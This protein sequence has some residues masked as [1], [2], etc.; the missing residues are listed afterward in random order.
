MPS[1]GGQ[2]AKF[3]SASPF[4]LFLSGAVVWMR[5]VPL[6]SACILTR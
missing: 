1:S 4:L 2:F 5:D 6:N 3:L